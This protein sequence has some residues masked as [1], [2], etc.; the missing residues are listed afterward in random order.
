M[1]EEKKFDDLGILSEE[2][3]AVG[4]LFKQ[5]SQ[6]DG[7]IQEDLI[8]QAFDPLLVHEPFED[9]H[10]DSKVQGKTEME[11]PKTL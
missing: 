9:F 11:E 2:E 4:L 7:V 1:K 3:D 6:Q 5:I 8:P 10:T